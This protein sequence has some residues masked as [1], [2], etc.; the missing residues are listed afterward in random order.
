MERTH[1]GVSR[2]RAAHEALA[3]IGEIQARLGTRIAAVTADPGLDGPLPIAVLC[4]LALHGSA[5]PVELQR[6]I[7]GTSGG[8]TKLIDRLERRGLV[9]RAPGAVDG[10][11]R[12]VVIT[13]TVAGTALAGRLADALMDDAAEVG[14]AAR[15]IADR[16]EPPAPR[17]ATA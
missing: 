2:R 15:G 11:R 8:T 3:L 6:I 9:A 10:D 7:H 16:L 5:R 14:A 12:G 1:R 13:L 4:H 17:E